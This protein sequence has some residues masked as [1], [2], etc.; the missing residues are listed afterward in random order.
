MLYAKLASSPLKID[1]CSYQFVSKSSVHTLMSITA[2][3]LARSVCAMG[4][5]MTLPTVAQ[6]R[7]IVC[8]SDAFSPYVIQE[9]DAIRGIDVDAIAKAGRRVGI[10]VRF[11]LLPWVRLERDIALGERSDV[12]CAFTYTLTDARKAYMDFTTVPVKLTELSLLVLLRDLR[13]RS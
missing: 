10:K 4:C 2:N 9:G 6:V 1:A 13:L 11:Q 12:E 5:L 7:E 3:W 8:Y